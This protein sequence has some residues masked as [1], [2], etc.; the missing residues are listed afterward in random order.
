MFDKSLSMNVQINKLCQA[1]YLELR[2]ISSIRHYLT[3]E[4]TA[5]LVSS[6]V[7]SRLDYANSLLAG[8]PQKCTDKL[9]RVM[10]CAA[11]LIYR[12]SKRDH[13]TPLLSEL[14]WLPI[15]QRIQYKIAL[16]CFNIISNTAPLYLSQLLELYTPSRSLRSSADTRTFRVPQYRRKFQG[17]RA[18]SYIG[19]VIWNSLPFH[20]RH[21]QST[22]SFKSKLKTHLFSIS[23]P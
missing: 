9:Q 1:G 14:H 7:L 3:K 8:L 12:S 16:I 17:G 11:R 15:S 21:A 10:N 4:A 18:F 23:Y 5:T 19:P 6:L 20:V 13:I 22:S 2:R